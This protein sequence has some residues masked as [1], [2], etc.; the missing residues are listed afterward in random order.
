MNPLDP[1]PV[2][3]RAICLDLEAS[4]LSPGGFPVEV[5][6][7]SV[8]TGEVRSWLIRPEPDWVERGVWDNNAAAIHGL[9][10]AQLERQGIAPS[11][12]VEELT[13]FLWGAF[14]LSDN[15]R[16]DDGW[17]R[18]LYAA[19]GASRPPADIQS[20]QAFAADLAMGVSRTPQQALE[21]A[22]AAAWVMFPE[23]HRA[24][25]DAAR[26]AAIVRR[27]AGW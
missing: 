16:H 6:V 2:L 8:A 10:L 26:N 25:P 22:E 9:T 11:S 23:Q 21:D 27:L 24:S 12:V 18:T 3:R 13:G 7:A 20:F 1:S 19:A 4:S 14:V 15:P 17:L 5:A